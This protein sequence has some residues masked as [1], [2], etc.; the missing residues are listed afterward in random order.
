MIYNRTFQFLAFFLIIAMN[1]CKNK[2]AENNGQENAIK[3]SGDS[4]IVP[5]GSALINKLEF[6][7]VKTQDF[8]AE[9]VTTGIIRPL[10]GHLAA[11]TTPFEG[12]VVTSFVRLGEKVRQGSPVF[13]LS[14]ADYFEA[15]KDFREALKEKEIAERNFARKK[16]LLEQGISSRKEFDDAAMT[17]EIAEKEYEKSSATLQVFNVKPEE[18][19]FT[20]PLIVRAP[21]SGEIVKNDI[22]IGQYLKSDSEPGVLL[23]DL[24]KIWVVAHVKEKDLGRMSPKDKVEVFAENLPDKPVA[25][26]VDYIGGIM[27][28]QTR[29]VE[30]YIECVNAGKLMKPGMFVTVK[31]YHNIVSAIIIPSSSVLQDEQSSFLFINAAPGIYLKRNV[32]VSSAE[33]RKLL[34]TSGLKQGDVVVSEGGIYLR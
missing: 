5:S 10:P 25:G 1:S 16:E 2:V 33:N 24:D 28:D 4:V 34:V 8:R 13:S 21:I 29:S 32:I 18:A 20:H 15:V 27:E 26:T 9:Y 19:D 3:K 7:T 14:S 12:R 17:S 23:A 6:D 30:V 11:V 22:T 31:F